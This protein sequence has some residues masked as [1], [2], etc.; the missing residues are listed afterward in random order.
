[1]VPSKSAK[2][3]LFVTHTRPNC[4]PA[5]QLL[6]RA[7]LHTKVYAEEDMP[8]AL[9]LGIVKAPTLVLEGAGAPQ[10]FAG[11]EGIQKYIAKAQQEIA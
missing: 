10:L 4:P 8:R 3:T 5:I 9:G 7:K 2:A 11:L 1:M 6:E